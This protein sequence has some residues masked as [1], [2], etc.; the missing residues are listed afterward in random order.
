MAYHPVEQAQKCLPASY[1]PSGDQVCAV[2]HTWSW[3][4]E[5][6]YLQKPGGAVGV[7]TVRSVSGGPQGAVE[8]AGKQSCACLLPIS[9]MGGPLPLT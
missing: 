6:V 4:P 7:G 5:A 9:F 8:G 1:L 2:R 3:L